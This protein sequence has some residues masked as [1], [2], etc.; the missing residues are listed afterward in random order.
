[1]TQPFNGPTQMLNQQRIMRVLLHSLF[2]RREI[3]DTTTV[4]S[5][6]RQITHKASVFRALNWTAGSNQK[7]KI[8]RA[9]R[10]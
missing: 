6:N 3:I 8:T 7:F 9:E 2:K 4:T 5:H 1:M 10:Q